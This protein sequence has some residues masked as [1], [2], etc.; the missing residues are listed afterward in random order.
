MLLG[1]GFPLRFVSLTASGGGR[2]CLSD[3][4]ASNKKVE[5]ALDEI[6][7]CFGVEH[8]HSSM[9]NDD[10]LPTDFQYAF[11]LKTTT[12][13]TLLLWAIS[14]EER[15]IWTT[16][17]N[18]LVYLKRQKNRCKPPT[19]S[20]AEKLLSRRMVR[21]TDYDTI[22]EPWNFVQILQRPFIEPYTDSWHVFRQTKTF[23]EFLTPTPAYSSSTL[24]LVPLVCL[25]SLVMVHNEPAYVSYSFVSHQL[26]VQTSKKTTSYGQVCQVQQR[27]CDVTVTTEEH[28]GKLVQFKTPIESE[29]QIWFNE[30]S[31]E[32]ESIGTAELNPLKVKLL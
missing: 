15:K 4:P 26:F 10:E 1:R 29:A 27:G 14:A 21:L 13:Q 6:V 8:R 18:K 28:H 12:G 19:N 2:L 31:N 3:K 17:I 9:K 5:V 22:P 24:K 7:E 32:D 23:V 20:T 16:Q 30:L 11:A 25:T